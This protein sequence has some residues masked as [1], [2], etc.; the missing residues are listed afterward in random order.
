MAFDKRTIVD[1]SDNNPNQYIV[2][3]QV[4]QITKDDTGLVTQGTFVN[5]ELLQRYEDGFDGVFN[6]SVSYSPE[7]FYDNV[8]TGDDGQS[9]SVWTQIL[10]TQTLDTTNVKIGDSSIRITENDNTAGL[11]YSDANNISLDF[12]TLNNG[13][14]SPDTD[15]IYFIFYISNVSFVSNIILQLG[16]DTTITGNRKTLTI[17]SGLVTGWNYVKVQKSV[18]VTEGTGAWDNIQSMRILWTSLANAQNEYV[19]FQLIQ[20]VKKDPSA[21]LPNAFQQFGSRIAE[22]SGS[23]WFVGKENNKI[24][25]KELIQTTAT[26]GELRGQQT[27]NNFIIYFK[28]IAQSENFRGAAWFV[29][30]NN[31]IWGTISTNQLVLEKREAGAYS[32]VIVD[33][34]SNDSNPGDLWELVLIKNNQDIKLIAFQN[35]DYS[36][37]TTISS[38]TT[39]A[40]S[41]F[42]VLAF[43]QDSSNRNT[44]YLSASITEIAHAHHADIAETAKSLVEQPYCEVQTVGNQSIPDTTP[45][46]VLFT[47]TD[48]DNRNSFDT[49]TN[50]YVIP[51]TGRYDIIANI[52]FAPNS[53][54]YRNVNLQAD[55]VEIGNIFAPP[56]TG[57]ATD[58]QCKNVIKNFTR[59][60]R[61]KVNVAQ[62]T[63]GALNI[64]TGA[65]YVNKLTINKIG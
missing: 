7:T 46:K 8:K 31:N 30:S 62:T 56:A 19:S 51:E 27:F 38:T 43:P 41:S 26:I 35:Q 52:R 25:W 4:S 50:E 49:S 55:S 59:G 64:Q 5:A 63:G 29:D 6:N 21:N 47:E 57:A 28:N 16:Q 39:I 34:Q 58:I 36:N 65:G 37:P 33:L 11:L 20:L 22:I 3:G 10:G 54:G 44:Q 18:F 15:Y 48:E 32:N 2:D 13:E 17:S 24:L 12:T 1:R 40:T 61:I 42:G 23:E 9:I 53:T 14:T 60:Q 45:T